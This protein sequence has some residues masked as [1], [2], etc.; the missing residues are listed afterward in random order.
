MRPFHQQLL[1]YSTETYSQ[2]L[3]QLTFV[4]WLSL[5]FGYLARLL[6]LSEHRDTSKHRSAFRLSVRQRPS[7]PNANGGIHPLC[8]EI[9]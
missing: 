4:Q 8:H 7:T 9:A 5:F 2:I 3:L 1:I 6:P